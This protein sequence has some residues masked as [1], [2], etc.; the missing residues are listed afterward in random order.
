VTG[1]PRLEFVL[2]GPDELARLRQFR[3]G[4]PDVL[5]GDGGFGTW[6]ALI[7]EVNG[8]TVVT[9]YTL[10]ELLDRLALICPDLPDRAAL[11]PPAPRASGR[12]STTG[13]GQQ[14]V[15]RQLRV[16]RPAGTVTD[17]VLGEAGAGTGSQPP[18]GPSPGTASTSPPIGAG[19]SPFR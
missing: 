15:A 9:R 17:A 1:T 13:R 12:A 5:I 18:R 8:E 14:P 6:Q 10:R 11:P 19:H 2:D 7:P 16:P 4:H 3:A